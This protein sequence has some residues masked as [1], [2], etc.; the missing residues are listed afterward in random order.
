MYTKDLSCSI[1]IRLA[2]AELDFI[3][4]AAK[5]CGV[6]LSQFM[7]S[8]VLSACLSAEPY[9]A[10]F[11]TMRVACTDTVFTLRVSPLM[12]DAIAYSA[13]CRRVS[14]SH[15]CRFSVLSRSFF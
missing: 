14:L 10:L 13:T 4:D 8:C 1:S 7:R 9:D 11:D 2:Q 6:S 12:F 3:S 15:F 5:L